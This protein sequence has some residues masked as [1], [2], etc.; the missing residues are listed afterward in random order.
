MSPKSGR[1]IYSFQ[2]P[3]SDI[4]S[5][6]AVFYYLLCGVA[7][8]DGQDPDEKSRIPDPRKINPVIPPSYSELIMKM[9]EN[10]AENRIG[11]WVEVLKELNRLLAEKEI[12]QIPIE[13]QMLERVKKLS[14]SQP[15]P[16]QAVGLTHTNIK[17]DKNI[18]KMHLPKKKPKMSETIARLFP[19]S[20]GFRPGETAV[21][22]KNKLLSFRAGLAA[23][24]FVLLIAG[25]YLISISGKH[26]EKSMQ[27]ADKPSGTAEKKDTAPMKEVAAQALPAATAQA[28]TLSKFA[29]MMQAADNYASEHP[30]AL[31][32][33]IKMYEKIAAQA[34]DAKDVKMIEA[35]KDR[36]GALLDKRDKIVDEVMRDL[37]A[38]THPLIRD[39]KYNEAI[40]LIETYSG[41]Y[42]AESKSRRIMAVDN[43][44][45]RYFR[46]ENSV[47]QE[48][49][50]AEVK[51]L[52][53]L[54]YYSDA[55]DYLK[56]YQTGGLDVMENY[57][58]KLEDE[59]EAERQK[60]AKALGILSN[61]I[62]YP[63]FELDTA[64]LLKELDVA[65]NDAR[66]VA[67]KSILSNVIRNVGA[68]AES[69]KLFLEEMKK[70]GSKAVSLSFSGGKVKNCKIME[71]K[72]DTVI[73]NDGTQ[74][75]MLQFKDLA[76]EFKLAFATQALKLDD[77]RLLAFLFALQS[78][79]TVYA[80]GLVDKLPEGFN[81]T[82]R[83]RINEMLAKED[84]DKLLEKTGLTLPK[85]D[86]TQAQQILAKKE[87]SAATA[88]K[89]IP[90]L[91]EYKDKYA[92]TSF[93][94]GSGAAVLESVERACRKAGAV[95]TQKMTVDNVFLFKNSL[96]LTDVIEK[97]QPS[98]TIEIKKGKYNGSASSPSLNLYKP[99]L[100]LIAEEGTQFEGSL[101]ISADRVSVSGIEFLKGKLDINSASEVKIQNCIF[102]T[103]YSSI[104]SSVKISLENTL[105]KGLN[106]SSSKDV[107]MN[108]CTV[109][110]GGMIDEK[111]NA[112]VLVL[113]DELA[114]SNSV[115][116][117]DVY[118][119][120]VNEKL[121]K[122]KV[123][124]SNSV[125]YGESGLGAELADKNAVN[126]KSIAKNDSG[127]RKFMKT[128]KILTVAPVFVNAAAF[129][130]SLSKDSPGS[131]AASDN[132]DCGIIPLAVKK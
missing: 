11:S 24:I 77:S 76:P 20:S 47:K 130:Y 36:I 108:H 85:G 74:N 48:A 73:Y 96:T 43:L 68:F 127:L 121:D 119:I 93:I 105:L 26:D 58:D 37:A 118:A 9:T 84:L 56:A 132:K 2:Y 53:N 54:G 30:D 18:K 87:I 46:D 102:D 113:G 14:Q 6:G 95:I 44:K 35:T 120:V 117:G 39:G 7:P 33:S 13:P 42:A 129:D 22:K 116:Y 89:I 59:V 66:Y 23:L 104:K 5:A 61:R 65:M 86:Y 72:G 94:K 91:E 79:D 98:T 52:C 40:A 17:L 8:F 106:V 45:K 31:E 115:L 16:S 41:S 34:F 67:S 60:T 15:K 29:Q 92:S 49:I 55:L 103:G 88:A 126:P 101:K 90:L 78:G 50:A 12:D 83:Q 75:A 38:K 19:I 63:L 114:I 69:E 110:S 122:R 3:V 107:L 100:K 28:Q 81:T 21:I 25:I 125:I 71:I 131:G 57:R 80:S 82:A 64:T 123:S 70:Q 27:K 124:L 128:T 62:L 51:R 109:L 112:A 99:G 1:E 111:A 10:K 4:Y 32:I 97:A